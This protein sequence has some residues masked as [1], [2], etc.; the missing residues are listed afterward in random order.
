MRERGAAD[1]LENARRDALR[2]CGCKRCRMNLGVFI[3]LTIQQVQD[4]QELADAQAPC[5]TGTS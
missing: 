2:A 1:V 4:F 5:P 3:A